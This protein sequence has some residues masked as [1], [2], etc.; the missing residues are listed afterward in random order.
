MRASYIIITRC[1]MKYKK[2]Q[3]E[4]PIET[5]EDKINETKDDIIAF[6]SNVEMGIVAHRAIQ[7]YEHD[8]I[9]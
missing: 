9:C 6:N 3:D 4:D 1:Y 7:V 8:E 2:R 5:K